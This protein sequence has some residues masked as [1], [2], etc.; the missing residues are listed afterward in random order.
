MC[1]KRVY[2]YKKENVPASSLKAK[3]FMKINDLTYEQVEINAPFLRCTKVN[4]TWKLLPRLYNLEQQLV[5]SFL[6]QYLIG[7][8]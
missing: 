7:A 6:I 3:T 2:K 8:N 4:K 1:L 5:L